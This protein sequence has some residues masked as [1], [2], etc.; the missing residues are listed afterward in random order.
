MESNPLKM[1]AYC[2][3]AAEK[4]SGNICFAGFSPRCSGV[5]NSYN[6]FIICLEGKKHIVY[7]DGE[8]V[9]DHL[10]MSGD[11]VFVPGNGEEEE[12]WDTPHTMI[13]CVF[14]SSYTR[15]IYID[16]LN[17]GGGKPVPDFFY[18]I[19]KEYIPGDSKIAEALLELKE[20]VP[21]VSRVLL[22]A[23]LELIADS[24]DK[25]PALEPHPPEWDRICEAMHNLFKGDITREDMAEF[26][27]VT[28]SKLSRIILKNSGKSFRE[29]LND[30]RLEY[31][32][33]LLRN[34]SWSVGEIAASS[35]FSYTSYFIRLFRARYGLSPE[36]FRKARFSLPESENTQ[37]ENSL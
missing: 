36:L 8:E 9:R 13:S 26:V 3:S 25:I 20:S 15:V 33:G 17:P 6:R 30:H 28:P 2:R 21:G 27:G 31:A 34:S 4:I 11:T 14:M 23:L 32:L 16:H 10:L 12:K 22:Q 5:I 18:H 1:A 35:G 7:G 19:P 24:L 29:M 37:E